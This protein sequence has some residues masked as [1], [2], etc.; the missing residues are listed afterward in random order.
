[1]V[2]TIVRHKSFAVAFRAHRLGALGVNGERDLRSSRQDRKVDARAAVM[3]RV[4]LVNPPSRLVSQLFL[5]R[6]GKER[7]VGQKIETTCQYHHPPI[8]II[9]PQSISTTHLALVIRHGSP[10][11]SGQHALLRRLRLVP[12]DLSDEDRVGSD[13]LEEHKVGAQRLLGRVG[14]LD[15]ALA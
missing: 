10:L 7:L 15:V 3:S 1:V 9:I 11:G 2:D 13:A 5:F 12:K 8:N 4:A 6:L 14:I